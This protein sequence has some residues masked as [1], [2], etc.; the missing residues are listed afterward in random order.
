MQ[1]SLCFVLVLAALVIPAALDAQ[2]EP[3]SQTRPLRVFLDCQRC[4]FD[5]L[6]REVTFVD[7]VR[8]RADAQVHVLVTSQNTGAGGDQFAFYFIGQQEFAGRQDTL[9]WTSRQDNTED[10]VRDGQTRTFA[11]G[12]IPYASRTPVAEALRVEFE[13]PEAEARPSQADDPWNLWVFQA[14]A[15]GSLEGEETQSSRSLE[16]SIS[17]DR[18]TEELK[19]DLGARFEYNEDTFEDLEEDEKFTSFARDANADAL[20]VFSLGEHWAWGGEARI[21][22]STRDNQDLYAA[23]M[24]AIEYSVYP[25]SESTR[26]QI[27]FLYEIGVTYYDYDRLTLFDKFKETLAEQT[28][29][30]SAGFQQPW[31]EID[32]GVEW[33]NYLHDFGLHRLDF[34]SRIEVRLFRGLNLDVNGNVARIQNQL[35]VLRREDITDDEVLLR[36]TALGTDYQFEIEVGF[37][38]TFGSVFNN[39]VNPR[40][41]RG[42]GRDFNGFN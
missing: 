41:S 33:S 19:V 4:D 29:E 6:R 9:R 35:Y 38:Y 12:L 10:E 26:R 28:F 18:V 42:G 25:Y 13:A 8:D 30:I 16:G 22:S 31:G 32:A 1:R 21:G 24:P 3:P 20:V 39:V 27:T 14:R 40:M 7:Y 5:H 34:S 11:L 15:S 17:A 23:F 36:R 2:E 37:S